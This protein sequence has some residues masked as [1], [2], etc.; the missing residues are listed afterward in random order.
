MNSTDKE[1]NTR[2]YPLMISTIVPRPVAFVSS[3]STIRVENLAPFRGEGFPIASWSKP[4]AVSSRGALGYK[5][6][7]SS[8]VLR[9]HLLRGGGGVRRSFSYALRLP[10]DFVDRTCYK[11]TR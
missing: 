10:I 4:T 5:R 11:R 6:I 2:L 8:K 3:I 1:D 7:L 9:F